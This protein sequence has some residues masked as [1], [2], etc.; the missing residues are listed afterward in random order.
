MWLFNKKDNVH[1][2]KRNDF[3]MTSQKIRKLAMDMI[4]IHT[5]CVFVYFK[6]VSA[7]LNM[8]I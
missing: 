8:S 2:D 4:F 7:K 6:K 5:N 1:F 3:C